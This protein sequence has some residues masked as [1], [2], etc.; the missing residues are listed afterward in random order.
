MKAF[1]AAL[2]ALVLVLLVY[3]AFQRRDQPY[4]H[5]DHEVP[6]QREWLELEPVD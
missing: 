2:V 4:T 6:G 1:I 5:W 3:A